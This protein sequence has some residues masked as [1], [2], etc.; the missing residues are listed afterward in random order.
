MKTE[1]EIKQKIKELEKEERECQEQ[2]KSMDKHPESVSKVLISGFSEEIEIL[3]WV[4]K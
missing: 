2:V 4:L 1:K 3:K